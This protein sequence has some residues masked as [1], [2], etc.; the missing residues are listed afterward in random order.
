MSALNSWKSCRVLATDP[1]HDPAKGEWMEL[2]LTYAGLLL[3]SNKGDTRAKHKHEIRRVFHRQLKRLWEHHP[4]LRTAAALPANGPAGSFLTT[5]DEAGTL[6]Q[7]RAAQFVRNGYRFAP[8]ATT[9]LDLHCSLSILFLR[10]DVPGGI[11][12]S[13]DIDNR[14]KTLFDSLRMPENKDELGGYDTPAADEE[15]F[16]C[17]L[18]DDALISTVSVETDMMLEDVCGKYD[19]NHARLVVTANIRPY[20][21]TIRNIDFS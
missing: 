21:V 8:L 17:L 7:Q 3:G 5:P 6:L 20:F 4:V 10:P 18:Q 19:R 14:L 16:F 1:D 11:I 13:A 12:K 9:D 2:K 15:P